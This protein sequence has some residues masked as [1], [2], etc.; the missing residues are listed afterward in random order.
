MGSYMLRMAVVL[1]L[2]CDEH[3]IKS[4]RQFFGV[5]D[6][7]RDG[8]VLVRLVFFVVMSLT[9]GFHNGYYR[10]LAAY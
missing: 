6:N 5:S 2:K 3:L 7:I 9:I 8:V 10:F 4:Y 1:S